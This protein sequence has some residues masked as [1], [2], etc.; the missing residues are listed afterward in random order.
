MSGHIFDM[1]NRIAQ[2]K[3]SKSKKFKGDHRE[4]IYSE[5][6]GIITEY[7]FPKVSESSMDHI[8]Q[9]I[10]EE[11]KSESRKS[12]YYF[13][14]SILISAVV[15]WAFISFYDIGKYPLY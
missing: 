8:K 7:T 14:I 11:A 1:V 2:N 10:Q 5:N 12:I 15:I 13:I 6:N 4:N 9:V 3:T